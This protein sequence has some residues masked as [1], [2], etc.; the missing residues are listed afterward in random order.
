ME[1]T[2]NVLFKMKPDEY[3]DHTQRLAD[4]INTDKFEKYDGYLVFIT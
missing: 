1:C 4:M 2:F 3:T